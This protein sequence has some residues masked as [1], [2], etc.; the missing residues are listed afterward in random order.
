MKNIFIISIGVIINLF[1]IQPT[2]HADDGQLY[3]VNAETLKLRD[4]PNQSAT[5][6]AYLKYG[7]KVTVFQQSDG[8]GRTFYNGKEA[9]ISLYMLEEEG[10]LTESTVSGVNGRMTS[11]LL[12]EHNE[13]E[14]QKAKTFQQHRDEK[15]EELEGK[16]SSAAGI[17][18]EDINQEDIRKQS[19]EK[20]LSGYHFI[21]DPGH[22]GKDP[23]AVRSELYEKTITLSTAKKV[24]KQLR[25]KGASVTL[26]RTNDTFIAVEER[27]QL[28]N[29]TITSAFISLHYNA[30]KDQSI[31][32]IETFYNDVEG[33]HE[34]AEAIQNSLINHI[35]FTNRGA[36]Q[37]S[38]KVLRENKQPALLIELGFITNP[39]ERKLVRTDTY[40]EKAA[41]SIVSGLEDYFNHDYIVPS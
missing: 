24:V 32:G 37:A 19:G 1:I 4:E 15:S 41:K 5:V 26:T 30:F 40:Q 12:T 22:G 17:M 11:R 35:E 31:R 10:S 20:T 14:E 18:Q 21:I 27:V 28:S 33:T 34:L 23:G 39:K 7:S 36:K 2:V 25:D 6:L 16:E 13:E 8:W 38:Y 9:W 29:S 3:K